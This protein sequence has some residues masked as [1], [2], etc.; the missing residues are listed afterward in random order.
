MT[1][2]NISSKS[3]IRRDTG[4]FQILLTNALMQYG[5]LRCY[6]IIKNQSEVIAG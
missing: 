5:E 4:Q 1:P 2:R 6:L 3:K